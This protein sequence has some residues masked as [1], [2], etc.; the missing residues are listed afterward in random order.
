[1]KDIDTFEE[2]EVTFEVGLSKPDARGKWLKDGKIIYPDQRYRIIPLKFSSVCFLLFFFIRTVILS[3][4]K[5]HKLKIKNINL[6]DAGDFSFQCGDVKD[7][8]KMSVKECMYRCCF[9]IPLID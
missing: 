8:C 3:E 4:G 1:L 5:I 2:E 6:K 9:L 7:S